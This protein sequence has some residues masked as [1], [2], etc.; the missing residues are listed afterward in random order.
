MKE[1]KG[2]IAE[3]WLPTYENVTREFICDSL[4]RILFNEKLPNFKFEFREPE[5]I[6]FIEKTLSEYSKEYKYYEQYSKEI[7]DKLRDTSNQSEE[8]VMIVNDYKTFFESLRDIYE[9][10]IELF[11]ERTGCDAFFRYEKTNLFEQIWLRATPEDFN[12][13]ERFLKKQ[14]QMINDRTFEKY[15]K[16]TYVGKLESLGNNVLYAKNGIARTWDENFREMEFT[17]YDHKLAKGE[18]PRY[19][20]HY[21]FPVVR[22]GIYEK[23]G[24][25]VCFIGSIQNKSEDFEKNDIE[26]KVNRKKYKANEGVKEEGTEK[27][28]PKNLMALSIFINMLNAEGITDIEVPS[29]YVLDYDY[30][31]KRNKEILENF[32][33]RW[34]PGKRKEWADTYKEEKFYFDRQYNKQ[35]L[36]SEI[37]TERLLLTFERLLKHYSKGQL[38]S[39]PDDADNFM[40]LRIPKIKSEKEI[41]GSLFKELYKIQTQEEQER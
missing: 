39:G 41:N 26:K 28:E 15:D 23:D 27:V 3:S 21:L 38:I 22:Y 6:E 17:V 11:F 12:N 18:D 4:H 16:E 36:V 7:M 32:E 5:A 29:M 20:P 34:T 30:H 13:P 24:K 35:D 37:K 9:R 31:V 40:H 33:K 8:P 1:F 10:H 25:K 2:K 14:S 19:A